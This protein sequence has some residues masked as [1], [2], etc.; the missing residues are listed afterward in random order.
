[1][2]WQVAQNLGALVSRIATAAA[3]TPSTA[4]TST[5]T[6]CLRILHSTSHVGAHRQAASGGSEDRLGPGPLESPGI[7]AFGVEVKAVA[8]VLDRGDP[9]ALPGQHGDHALN[10]RGLAA[11]GAADEAENRREGRLHGS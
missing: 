7:L 5:I 1:M 3:P 4:T 2:V 11:V 8:G 10:E 9:V 6:T